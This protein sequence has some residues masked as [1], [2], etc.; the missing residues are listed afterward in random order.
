MRTVIAIAVL[1][2]AC[3]GSVGCQKDVHEVRRGDLDIA[4]PGGSGSA[5]ART[6][7]PQAPS[8]QP[9]GIGGEARTPSDRY[10]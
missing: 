2:L 1:S 3:V 5:A 10:R 7:G 6:G 8:G 4:A 9:K